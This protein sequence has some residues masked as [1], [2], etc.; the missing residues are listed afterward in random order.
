VLD[1]YIDGE[2]IHNELAKGKNEESGSDSS[3][4]EEII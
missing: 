1:E 4:E 2:R 3:S